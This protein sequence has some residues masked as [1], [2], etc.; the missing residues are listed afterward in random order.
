MRVFGRSEV[1]EL[2]DSEEPSHEHESSSDETESDSI[3]SNEVSQSTQQQEGDGSKNKNFFKSATDMVI[4]FVNKAT[5]TFATVDDD[6]NHTDGFNHGQEQFGTKESKNESKVSNEDFSASSPK[7]IQIVDENSEELNASEV[8]LNGTEDSLNKSSETGASS[9]TNLV[10]LLEGEDIE[11]ESD[12]YQYI[13]QCIFH[14]EIRANRC[15]NPIRK[16]WIKHLFTRRMCPLLLTEIVET[17]QK[18]LRN[19]TE[20]SEGKM[21]FESTSLG[22]TSSDVKPEQSEK[23]ERINLFI[24]TPTGEKDW[25]SST[26]ATSHSSTSLVKSVVDDDDDNDDRKSESVDRTVFSPSK[27]EVKASNTEVTM[28]EL[29]K[30]EG[31]KVP[32]SCDKKVMEQ[33]NLSQLLGEAMSITKELSRN[34]QNRYDTYVSGDKITTRNATKDSKEKDADEKEKP[35]N[36]DV[37]VINYDEQLKEGKAEVPTDIVEEKA[38][39]SEKDA[40]IAKKVIEDSGKEA[41][42][43]KDVNEENIILNNE[44]TDN[45]HNNE[46][47]VDKAVSV[48]PL[49]EKNEEQFDAGKSKLSEFMETSKMCESVIEKE[50][51]DT[52]SST[53]AAEKLKTSISDEP[54]PLTGE[55]MIMNMTSIQPSF[56]EPVTT[57]LGSQKTQTG[58]EIGTFQAN[59]TKPSIGTTPSPAFVSNSLLT[60]EHVTVSATHAPTQEN[61]K[62]E[63]ELSLDKNSGLSD[64]LSSSTEQFEMQKKEATETLNQL[65]SS[66]KIGSGSSSNNK[67]SAILKLKSRVKEL[68]ANLTLSTL[69]LE[70]MSKRY[71]TALEEQQKQFKAKVSQ[72]NQTVTENKETI[73]RQQ[74]SIEELTR[75][76]LILSLRLQNFTEE[77]R[78]HNLKVGCYLRLAYIENDNFN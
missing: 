30:R 45:Y 48:E 68:E 23:V 69:Y 56:S 35:E 77:A 60:S 55:G 31:G 27:T 4:G 21:S 75:Q 34:E 6:K 12:N 50:D 71:G 53:I 8:S 63:V 16:F 18:L 70:E 19:N 54:T 59:I 46:E 65:E 14:G 67:E 32:G 5:K 1:E 24:A 43:N 3:D 51:E 22:N 52:A 62:Q 13:R 15:A 38:T 40:G 26:E 44:I 39:I 42:K 74:K 49:I 47:E 72:L 9:S 17:H 10:I 20:K 11:E 73:E 7:V 78:E 28:T 37:L 76:I 2:D 41:A 36:V 61:V 25:S 66:V 57:G 33:P 64:S 58:I 29:M